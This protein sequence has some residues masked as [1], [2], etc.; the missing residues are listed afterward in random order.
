VSGRYPAG[1][2]GGAD[3]NA[4]QPMPIP[5]DLRSLLTLEDPR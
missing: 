4:L 3:V 2:T 1:N 5:D